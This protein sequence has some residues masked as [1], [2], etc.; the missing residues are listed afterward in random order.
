VLQVKSRKAVAPDAA[1][2]IAVLKRKWN[3][4]VKPGRPLPPF[5]EIVLGS[6]GRLS[7]HI[8]VLV[9]NGS[10]FTVSRAGHAISAWLG[11]DIHDTPITELS[12]DCGNAL[13]EA[14][15]GAIKGGHPYATSAYCVRDGLVETHDVLAL[16]LDNRWGPAFVAVYARESG[17]RYDLVD[18]IFRST[19]DGMLALAVLRDLANNPV[20]FQVVDLNAGASR[21]L[22]Q[23]IDD[24]RWRKLSQGN[25]PLSTPE[26]LSQFKHVLATG[27]RRQF[28]LDVPRG[29]EKG[30]LRI[31]VAAIG[32]LLSVTLTDVSDLK[33]REQSFRLLYNDNPMP[34]FVVDT[35]SGRVISANGA[36]TRH[37]GYSHD[38]FAAL[39]LSD[40]WAEG[41][42]QSPP[43]ALIHAEGNSDAQRSWR[44]VRANGS[45][46]E[47]LLFG[48]RITIDR[49]DA[50]LIAVVDITE[51]RKAEARVAYLAHH[52]ALTGL[53]NRVLYRERLEQIMIQNRRGQTQSAILCLDLDL[54]KN[55]NDSFGHPTGDGLLR[56][57]AQRLKD[58]LGDDDFV[59]RIGGDEFAIVLPDIGGP[60]DASDAAT[61]LIDA[62]S[63]PYMIDG[64]ELVISASVGI[65]MAPADGHDADE[66]L[67]NADMALYRA[68][69]DGRRTHRFFEREMDEQVQRRRAME[70]DLRH[71]LAHGEFELHYQPLVDLESGRVTGFESLLRWRHPKKGMISPGDFIPIAEETGLIMPIG[72]WVVRN[73]CAEAARWPSDIKVAV[74]LSPVQF[75]SNNLVQAVMTALAHSGLSPERLELEITESVLLVETES[76]LATLHRL[77]ELGVRISLD[78][79]GTG[80]SS[81]SYLRS[82]PFDKIKIDSSFVRELAQRIDSAAIVRAISGI[83]KSLGVATTAEGVETLEQLDRI[84]M[85]GCTEVQGFLFSEAKPASEVDALIARFG[86]RKSDA[87]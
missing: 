73:A 16:P 12:P 3:A 6:L 50:C 75:R 11:R 9:N 33:R 58:S 63:A 42:E 21:L 4:A 54:F 76:N 26:A 45:E 28:E 56:T 57:V 39:S 61:R 29:Q 48:R 51:R 40:L 87:A 46:I 62:L 31:N 49:R 71:A 64:V 20:D 37:Y 8:A 53:P 17:K 86:E 84:R 14:A 85:E 27:D 41:E 2:D 67:R 77:R 24:L 38:R 68:K 55:V 66:L 18:T 69:A 13:N 52:D 72:E 47:V 60:H 23:Q 7:D 36:A 19:E 79:F 35:V 80:Y 83:G 10:S 59:A 32:D 15:A 5:E 65:A 30:F 22:Q 25:H 78:D 82:F 74:N 1:N 70:M 44:H 43:S 34:M 81:L